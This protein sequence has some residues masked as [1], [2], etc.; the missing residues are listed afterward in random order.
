M[1]MN[2]DNQPDDEAQAQDNNLFTGRSVDDSSG[3][4][5]EIIAMDDLRGQNP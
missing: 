1:K 2:F 4:I 3:L 5:D